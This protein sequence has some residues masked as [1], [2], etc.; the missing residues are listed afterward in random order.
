MNLTVFCDTIPYN[1]IDINVSDQSAESYTLKMERAGSSKRYYPPTKIHGN[2]SHKSQ[3]FYFLLN[4]LSVPSAFMF[5][6]C[7]F[8]KF[9][10]LLLHI[11]L[12]VTFFFFLQ[13]LLVLPGVKWPG[14]EA[15][16]SPPF[17]AEVRKGGAIQPLPHMSSWLSA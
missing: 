16:L 6:S 1:L 5:S 12:V 4:I 15:C 2:L 3:S 17:S 9:I 7:L 14:R 8:V 10:P 11:L 13:Y